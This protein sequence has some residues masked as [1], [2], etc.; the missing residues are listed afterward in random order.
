MS[1]LSAAATAG[2]IR[3]DVDAYDLLRAIGYL[4]VASGDEGNAHTHRMLNLLTDGL[5]YSRS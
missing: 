3:R 2:G 5:R 4:S 1:L